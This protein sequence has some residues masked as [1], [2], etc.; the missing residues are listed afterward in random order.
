VDVAFQGHDHAYLRTPPM[1]AGKKAASPA[2]GTIYVVAC[3]G[4]KFYDAGE[5]DYAAVMFE[6]T[7][8]W[9]VIDIEAGAKNKLT[10]RSF[11]LEG[12]L[13]D[14]FSIEKN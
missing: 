7:P 13:R 11:D 5:H 3:A 10:Y 4:D 1:N 14:E 8:T 9:Q 6:K 2:D 12:K